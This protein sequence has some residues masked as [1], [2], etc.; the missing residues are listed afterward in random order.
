MNP[1]QPAGQFTV[2]LTHEARADLSFLLERAKHVGVLSR[3]KTAL[4][5]SESALEVDPRGWGEPMRRYRSAR[6]MIY[7]RIHDELHIVYGVH[8]VAPLVWVSAI[9]PVL[10]HPLRVATE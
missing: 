1:A 10:S 5:D 4:R 2:R 3:F 9:E 6:L 8:D 7:H